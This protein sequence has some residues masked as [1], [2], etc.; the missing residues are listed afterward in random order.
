MNLRQLSADN[1][2]MRRVVFIVYL[3]LSLPLF[4]EVEFA[5]LNLSLKN[6]LLFSAETS[7]P[8]FGEYKTV[9][10]ADLTQRTLK[11]LTFFPENITLVA[12]D[13]MI[14]F[15]NRFGVFRTSLDFIN[16]QAVRK[17]P[18]FTGGS[19]IIAGKINTV[20][21]SPDGNYLVYLKPV[22]SSY[23]D[24]YLFDVINGKQVLISS[25]VKLSFSGPGAVWSPDSTFFI[26]SKRGGLYY[27]SIDQYLDNRSISEDYRKLGK[28]DIS[29]IRWSSRNYLYY[30]SDSL[31]YQI[32]SSELFTRSLYSDILKVG[33]IAGKIPFIFDPEFDSF[34]IS[35]DGT[36]MLFNKAGRNLFLYYLSAI[37]LEEDQN[38]L[39]LPY[40]YLPRQTEIEQILWSPQDVITILT[41][42]YEQGSK[43][44]A[45]YRM[46]PAGGGNT[47]GFV[48]LTDEG[49]TGLVPDADYNYV[50]VLKDDEIRI[51]RYSTWLDSAVIPHPG[52]L[53]CLWLDENNII[54]AGRQKT[55]S[56]NI[57][58]GKSSLISFSQAESHAFDAV[59]NWAVLKQEDGYY[60]KDLAGEWGKYKENKLLD[61]ST[62]SDSWRIYLQDLQS[63]PYRNMIMVRDIKGYGTVP[64]FAYPELAYES[65]PEADDGIDF[66]NFTHGSRIRRREV[67]LVFNAIDGDEGLNSIL[68]TLADYGLKCTFFINGEFISR[69]P[70]AAREIANSGHE[71][72]SLFYAYFEM[73]DSRYIFTKDK[74]KEGLGRNEDDFYRA[75]GSELA[76]L[77]HAPYYFINTAII[78]ASEEMN[79]T[80]VGR[81][82]D[83]LEW[84]TLSNNP[85]SV[86]ELVEKII[87]K[88]KPGSII[89]IRV[90]QAD[91]GKTDYL[92]TNLDLLINSLVLLGYEIVP[93]STL[94]EHAR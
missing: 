28:G 1:V 3:I 27:Y 29:S 49:I 83:P 46:N 47:L 9:F 52:P 25:F 89:P 73:T 44:T 38:I 20:G 75:T 32:I 41:S 37:D 54:I 90:G 66:A 42:A 56:V 78:S 14:Q 50:A 84:I 8:V 23:A 51:K 87:A 19:E 74:I 24:L 53:H 22:S 92:F 93:V 94:I 43:K 67:S 68:D 35:P 12:N 76:L 40:L 91:D 5:D 77:W 15:Q 70:Q 39:S 6:K 80:Y 62:A 10:E 26:Y 81:D 36:K 59:T 17:F 48:K 65:F 18:S 60:I 64:L 55:E 69:N 21:T 16:I 33:E 2:M 11:Q 13:E 57:N 88:K 45:V 79:Y 63:G 31:V 82:V 85:A 61:I 72:G 86:T 34:E 4:A 30:I 71:V 7:S 58:S